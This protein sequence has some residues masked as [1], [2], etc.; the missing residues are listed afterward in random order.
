MGS[1]SQ[2]TNQSDYNDVKTGSSQPHATTG[3][4]SSKMMHL[5]NYSPP[6]VFNPSELTNIQMVKE[7]ATHKQPASN[8]YI[9][10]GAASP[11]ED[12]A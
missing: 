1:G 8:H 7:N 9:N 12:G 4:I 11:G 3:S 2:A 10:G 5:R 6:P